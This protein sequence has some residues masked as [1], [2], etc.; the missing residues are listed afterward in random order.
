M[1]NAQDETIGLEEMGEDALEHVA[2]Y[3]RVLSVPLRLRILNALRE[4]ERS[5]GDL[6]ERLGRS[7]ANVSRHLAI[8]TKVASWC[9]RREAPASITASPTLA[10]SRYASWSAAR[11]AGGLPERSRCGRCSRRRKR[12]VRAISPSSTASYKS[13]RH[14]TDRPRPSGW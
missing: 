3:F 6:A 7:Q 9:A 1:R 4:G 2:E 11:S 8:L 10:P 5:V 12:R 14:P 13:W